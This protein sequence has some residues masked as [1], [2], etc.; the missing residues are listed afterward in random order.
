MYS[1]DPKVINDPKHIESLGYAE[2][3]ELAESGAP[4]LNATAVEFAKE[5]EIALLVRKF[6]VLHKFHKEMRRSPRGCFECGDT[7]HF[8]ADCLK[9]KKLDSSNKYN[10]NNQNDSSD[11]GESKRKLCAS[12][13]LRYVLVINDNYLVSLMN[14]N[15]AKVD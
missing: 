2:M 4:V 9:R 3:Q 5:R 1:A 15:A 6:H 12:K 11:K 13:P 7:T 14:F 10:Y 8:I